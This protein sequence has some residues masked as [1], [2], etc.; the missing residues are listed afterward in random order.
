MPVA[1]VEVMK[2]YSSLLCTEAKKEPPPNIP[3]PG[4]AVQAALATAKFTALFTPRKQNMEA[5]ELGVLHP[6]EQAVRFAT[7]PCAKVT[8]ARKRRVTKKIREAEGRVER[9]GKGGCMLG[10]GSKERNGGREGG[11]KATSKKDRLVERERER[12][13]ERAGLSEPHTIPIPLRDF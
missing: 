13:R 10:G 8:V 2:L 3:D 12:P 11:G 5:S 1:L 7:W 9:E 6:L 4:S